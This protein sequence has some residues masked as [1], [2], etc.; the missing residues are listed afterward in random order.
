MGDM[1]STRVLPPEYQESSTIDIS[2]DRRFALLLNV[3][4]IILMFVFGWLFLWAMMLLRAGTLGNE[5]IGFST[6][7]LP[8]MV[9]LI[10]WIIVLLA[11]HIIL[12]EA[13]HGIFF[14][15]FTRSRPVFAF[16]WKYAYAA[17][18]GWYIN[19]LPFLITTLAPL[20]VITAVGLLLMSAAPPSWLLG[21]WFV[22]TMNASGAVGDM[23]VAWRLLTSPGDTLVEDRGDALTFYEK[24]SGPHSE[25]LI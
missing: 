22:I 3:A 7:S 6:G 8:D 1:T 17:A 23:V 20:V 10:F 18:P 11:L 13:I 24:K 9:R 4:G 2:Q 5:G 14:W 16:R 25:P 15:L 12:H 19:R 21:I